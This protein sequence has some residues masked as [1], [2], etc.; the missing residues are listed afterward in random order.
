[1]NLSALMEKMKQTIALSALS[2]THLQSVY[3]NSRR[4]KAQVFQ[5]SEMTAPD[6]LLRKFKIIQQHHRSLIRTSSKLNSL[7]H[8]PHTIHNRIKYSRLFYMEH[9][10]RVLNF[11]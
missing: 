1:M 6:L 3:S 7:T 8:P 2:E 4:K 5:N 10:S 9:K 11:R